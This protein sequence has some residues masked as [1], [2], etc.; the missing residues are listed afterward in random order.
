VSASTQPRR[1]IIIGA[2][3]V[4]CLLAIGLRGRSFEVDVYE[5]TADPRVSPRRGHS[6]NL[7]LT[8]RGVSSLEPCLRDLAYAQGIPLPQR[9][10]HHV[11]GPPS[12]QRYGTRPE[13]HLLSVHRAVLHESFLDEAEKAGAR[14]HF[15]H[16][17]MGVD[18]Q[19]GRVSLAVRGEAIQHT[20]ADLVVGCDGANSIVRRDMARHGARMHI[21]QEYVEHGFVEL[22]MPPTPDDGFA[23]RGALRDDTV[24]A[25]RDHGLHIWPRGAY[26][27]LSQPNLDRS[28]TTSLFLPLFAQDSQPDVPSF[29]TVRTAREV[30]ALFDRR[31]PG[32]A[33]LLPRL[34]TD[35]FD[36]PP[37]SLRIVKCSPYHHGRAVL[38]GDS[39]HTLV[40]FYGQGINCSFED[41]K[42]FL[43]TLDQALGAGA[44]DPIPG[45]LAD[46][47]DLRL[48]SGHAITQLSLDHREEL[49]SAVGRQ[50]FAT[51][52]RLERELH[53]RH[54][55]EFTPLYD[56]VA[57]T[58]IPYHEVEARH[59][60]QRTI[61]DELCRRYDPVRD[62]D[63][64]ITD[65]LAARAVRSGPV[66]TVT[67]GVDGT[68]PLALTPAATERL[69]TTV[70]SRVVDYQAGLESGR[71]PA[72][73]L[74]DSVNVARYRDGVRAS[75][76]L[77]EPDVPRDGTDLQALLDEIFDEAVTNGTVHPHPGF[78]A[79]VPSGGLVQSA[80]GDLLAHIL[81]RFVGVWGASP[82]FSQIEAN[83]IRWFCTILGYG[84]SGFG[85]LTTGGSIANFMAMRCALERLDPR[86]RT[87]A[88]VYV[89]EQGHFSVAKAA[90]LAGIPADQVRHVATLP[91]HTMDVAAL[92]DAI[93]ADRRRGLTPACVVATAGTTNTGAVDDLERLAGVCRAERIWLHVDACFGGFFRLTGRGRRLLSGIEA[94]DSIA[95][96][97]H[98]SL[99]L[100]HGHSALLVRDREDLRAA[101]EV[102]GAPYMAGFTDRP[103]LVDMCNYGP[104]L[105]REV[106]GLAA[107]LPIKLHGIDAFRRCLDDRMD[108]ADGLADRLAEFDGIEVA[109]RGRPHLPVVGFKLRAVDRTAEDDLNLRLCEL[110][111][112]RGNI[113]LATTRLPHHGVVLRACVLHHRT[114][115]AVVDQLIEDLTWSIRNLG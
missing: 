55:D 77:R 83:V 20:S 5:S 35:F 52:T 81:N 29:Q 68:G 26:W 19:R 41:V 13:H 27:L 104:E 10:V 103:D 88:A 21:H 66:P 96:D 51:R 38:L 108:L 2:G 94:G 16:Q 113:Y 82:G 84:D 48:P 98:K 79:H 53:R 110:M 49:S 76:R 69:L 25:S 87:T 43:E 36:S 105:S 31:F 33:P 54:P 28:Y 101:F 59:E 85:Y 40:P 14:I 58:N 3:P 61:L 65:Y 109:P 60:R 37:A 115:L 95:V 102:P 71:Y 64:I 97:A 17:C 72:S 1:A 75:E 63:R 70:V 99:F 15:E 73:Y 7:T 9:V 23:L 30:T 86:T 78:L 6:F 4:G 67:T 62:I 47:T 22:K 89:S 57:F 93:E 45:V 90:R 39:S 42:V 100:P 11:A 50:S 18:P 111:S 24:P 34:T 74:H 56:M 92:L 12:Y 8:L 112:S 44:S 80:V 106:R 114:D 107:W 91:D 46:F 32:A